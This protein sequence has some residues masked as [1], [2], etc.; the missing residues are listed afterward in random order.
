MVSLGA[1]R[2]GKLVLL[3]VAALLLVAPGDAE[4]VHSPIQGGCTSP[5]T[6]HGFCS[7]LRLGGRTLP[8]FELLSFEG[9]GRY[10]LCFWVHGA[11]EACITRKL[12]YDPEANAWVARVD[13][14][15]D[16]IKKTGYTR[17]RWVDPKTGHR[18]GP[19]LHTTSVGGSGDFNVWVTT[20]VGP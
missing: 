7:A 14:E 5:G 8:Y 17:I 10:N 11:P 2:S 16:P 1:W 15:R 9:V 6:N 3:A 12:R 20:E 19:P 13:I 4:A 18:I